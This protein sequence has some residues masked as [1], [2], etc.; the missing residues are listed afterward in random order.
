MEVILTSEDGE[1]FIYW[2]QIENCPQDESEE[3]CAIKQPRTWDHSNGLSNIPEDTEDEN[4]IQKLVSLL[5]VLPQNSTS[6]IC[7]SFELTSP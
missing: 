5:V 3:D 4:G 1:E 2:V 7:K 6:L